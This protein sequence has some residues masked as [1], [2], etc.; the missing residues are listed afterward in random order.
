MSAQE[1]FPTTPITFE[2]V[3]EVRLAVV[4]YGGVSL[5]IYINGI[6]QEMLRFVRATAPLN[7]LDSDQALLKESQLV[8]SER[9]YRQLGQILNDPDHRPA[10]HLLE[11]ID[12]GAHQPI[13]TRFVVDILSGTSAGGIN[14]IFLAKALANNQDLDELQQ[15]WL[16]QGDIQ[17]LINDHQSLKPRL[18][19][20]KP[21]QSL[22]NSNRMYLE[23]LGA[24]DG[25]DAHSRAQGHP[26]SPSPLL[27]ELDLF[28][29]T[30]DIRGLTVPL[31]LTDGVVYEQRHKSVFHF[32]YPAD[33][34]QAHT[35]F[36][37]DCNPFLAF[38]ARCTSAFPFAFE[39][40]QLADIF[41][42]VTTAQLHVGAPYCD[43]ATGYWDRF[44]D[45][46]VRTD[47]ARPRSQPFH[48]RAFGD[49]GYLDNKPFSYAIDT[50]LTRRH[51]ALPIERKLVYIEP[52][53]DEFTAAQPSDAARPNAIENSLA[54][55]LVLPR[56][57]TIREDLE[58]VIHRNL[59][60]E[61]VDRIVADVR[62]RIS[63]PTWKAQPDAW[64]HSKPDAHGSGYATYE[65][66]KVSSVTDELA[67][68][69]TAAYGID[70]NGA[71]GR[72]VRTLAG[73]W[74]DLEYPHTADQR[75]FLFN[76]DVEYRL[77]RIRYIRRRIQDAYAELPRDLAGEDVAGYRRDYR[78]T[79]RDI[80]ASLGAPYA[81]LQRLLKRPVFAANEVPQIIF[82][83][84]QMSLVAQPPAELAQWPGL[85]NKDK[86][87]HVEE[88]SE[89]GAR[90][91]A[92]YILEECQRRKVVT[93][94][95][96]AVAKRF[97]PV[98]IQ[99]SESIRASFDSVGVPTR[100]E[101][102]ARAFVRREYDDFEIH[103]SAAFPITFGT[104]VD[105]Y[106]PVSIHRI[107]PDDATARE[108]LLQ[109]RPKLRGQTF[110]SFG[111]FL[112][113]TWR[114]NDI[115]WGRL[116]AAERLIAMTLPGADQRAVELRR[117]LVDR[118]HEEIVSE[119][120]ELEP[121]QRPRWKQ[122]LRDFMVSIPGQPAPEVVAKSAARCTA[123]TGDL[124][125]GI[126]DGYAA[127]ARP[128][129]TRM[130]FFGRMG[131][132]FIEV[133]VPHTLGELLGNYWMQLLFLF[134][135]ML[136]L[137]AVVTANKTEIA[138]AVTVAAIVL[139][140]FTLRQLLRRFLRGAVV[141]SAA[142]V[143]ILTILATV[144]L[145][146]LVIYLMNAPWP[147]SRKNVTGP[148]TPWYTLPETVRIADHLRVH[149]WALIFLGCS[150]LVTLVSGIWRLNTV[151]RARS[152][153]QR[154]NVIRKLK[155]SRRWSD[156]TDA[157]GLTTQ[158]QQINP[159]VAT[160]PG[161]S[162]LR[163]AAR[164][165]II[166]ASG[167]RGAVIQALGADHVFTTAYAL[168]FV[169]VVLCAAP[170][171]W[172]LRH[173]WV[174]ATALFGVL[175]LGALG[176]GA[177]VSNMIANRRILRVLRETPPED[178]QQLLAT[179]PRPYSIAKWL[180]IAMA[181]AVVIGLV[182]GMLLGI[183]HAVR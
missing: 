1:P 22:L 52:N 26:P 142:T 150:V 65:R 36:G 49:G 119:F 73:A 21:P 38:A 115:L 66:L 71:F 44:Y 147:G 113:P 4:I 105:G 40:M 154:M 94:L 32:K 17:E 75:W 141:L 15:L 160:D 92:V 156:V 68:L 161:Q 59:E 69:L 90:Q 79:F 43:P 37:A 118:A 182:S 24:L 51:S 136:V 101:S 167:L 20:Q 163:A 152:L 98:L 114:K 10:A 29:T 110:G 133:S 82:T 18:R 116:D 157:L 14:A 64:I 16:S 175:G 48:F 135:A 168:T 174:L 108:D 102:D 41:P 171:A 95:A 144:A 123:V 99:A 148:E 169:A 72:A 166:R 107:S 132:N 81:A 176:I 145:T 129:F 53:P 104:D 162:A 19:R 128:L 170:T 60:I 149:Q 77:R 140:L 181:G 27:E 178:R 56:Y 93:A 7:N 47:H 34:P 62:D 39:P 88:R 70:P 9:V 46:Y 100:G 103:D 124:L 58:R 67:N 173:G 45:D 137:L 86:Y 158:P 143:S 179:P 63:A 97:Q 50:T 131:W 57:E 139:G 127:R 126:S 12:N 8:S 117:K 164:A 183:G 33:D 120:L 91:R 2:P 11:E 54:A 155:F 96:K 130:A 35:D 109:G 159:G 165:A 23:L 151:H 61:R 42:I 121:T 134:A 146:G 31:S 89:R 122:A 153:N 6:V 25:M 5:A 78:K 111:A 83:T 177:A 112:D 85:D 3:K 87:P 180:T 138:L 80:K 106:G 84:D 28:S 30:T 172:T 76:F 55:L 74:R 13:R 125:E